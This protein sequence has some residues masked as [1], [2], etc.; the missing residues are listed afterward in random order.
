MGAASTKNV[1]KML[2]SSSISVDTN[3]DQ[4]SDA[5][6]QA[7][8]IISQVCENVRVTNKATAGSKPEGGFAAC[9]IASGVGN[10]EK[11]CS[12]PYTK[13]GEARV[14][15]NGIDTGKLSGNAAYTKGLEAYAW[16]NESEEN[17]NSC[18]N[19]KV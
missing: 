5:Q 1:S 10:K 18:S 2:Q 15:G 11:T 6:A 3:V 16:C 12:I 8:N 19:G 13:Q 7:T 4:S 14:K 9:A 17:C